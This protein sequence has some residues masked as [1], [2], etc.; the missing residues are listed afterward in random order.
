MKNNL[1]LKVRFVVNLWEKKLLVFK[2]ILRTELQIR[3]CA[4]EVSN[5][6]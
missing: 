3:D 4:P 1:V 6:Y 2:A 5:I